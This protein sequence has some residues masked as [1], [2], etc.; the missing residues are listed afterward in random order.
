[1]L[2]CMER[3]IILSTLI[4][5]L[6][7]CGSREKTDIRIEARFKGAVDLSDIMNRPERLVLS[8]PDTVVVGAIK[9]IIA[10][11]GRFYLSDGMSIHVYTDEGVFL[12]KI[13]RRGRGPG[14]YF[15]IMDFCLCDNSIYIIDRSPKLLKYGLDGQPE[16]SVSLDFFPATVCASADGFLCLSSAYQSEVDKFHTYSPR[17]LERHSSFFPIDKAEMTYRHF[18]NQ[19]TFFLYGDML[20]YHETM[21]N[22][23]LEVYRDSVRVF[24][25]FDLMGKNPPDSFFTRYYRNVMDFNM[26]VNDKGYCVGMPVYAEDDRTIFFTYRDGAS[27]RACL[28]DKKT[29][30]SEQFSTIRFPDIETP[31]EVSDLGFGF[32]ADK[33]LVISL[34]DYLDDTGGNDIVVYGIWGD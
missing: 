7:S 11:A 30:E 8:N 28:Y 32:L 1:M 20:L 5:I 16:S 33:A 34:P 25:S 31:V 26:E 29:G 18:M 17:T 2:R 22:N 23:V 12:F 21:N 6:L 9:K 4:F 27:Y 19:Q 14:E 13:D 3:G 24:H 10:D 15:D